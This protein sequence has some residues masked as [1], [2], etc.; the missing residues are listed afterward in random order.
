MLNI[1]R[2]RRDEYYK[3]LEREAQFLFDGQADHRI[4]GVGA[5]QFQKT[6]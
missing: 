3:L 1:I 2:S 4:H 5:M 6:Y